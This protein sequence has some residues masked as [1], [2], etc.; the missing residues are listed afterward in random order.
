[1]DKATGLEMEP[2]EEPTQLVEWFTNNYK[3]WGTDLQ[4]VSDKSQEGSQFVKG[5]GGVGG[6]LR[7]KVNMENLTSVD[8]D[9]EDEFYDSDESGGEWKRPSRAVAGQ[10]N[11]AAARD[12]KI[13]LIHFFS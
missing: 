13:S 5:F 7:Y 3:T 9:D 4:F 12:D 2:T 1:M 11:R 10:S 8:D 6:L